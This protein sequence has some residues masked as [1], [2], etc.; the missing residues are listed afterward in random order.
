MKNQRTQEQKRFGLRALAAVLLMLVALTC[1][2]AITAS[3]TTELAVTRDDLTYPNVNGTFAADLGTGTDVTALFAVSPD[4]K[5]SAAPN[6]DVALEIV[7]AT[8]ADTKLGA[9]TVTVNLALTGTDAG[10]YTVSTLVIPAMIYAPNDIPRIGVEDLTF[11][12]GTY[13]NGSYVKEYNGADKIDAS[14]DVTLDTSSLTLPA[15]VGLV[16]DTVKLNAATVLEAKTLT[17]TFKLVDLDTT[18]AKDATESYTAPDAIVIPAKVTPKTVR[19]ESGTVATAIDLVYGQTSYDVD[20][21]SMLPALNAGDII[22]GDT[23]TVTSASNTFNGID[24]KQTLNPVINVVISNTN[25]AVEAIS[26]TVTVNPIV[27]TV[28]W[29]GVL[30]GYSWGD[31]GVYLESVLAYYNNN[32]VAGT[33]T[34]RL[35]VTVWNQDGS[36]QQTG[37]AGDVGK[38]RFQVA[39]PDEDVYAIANPYATFEITPVVFD[40]TMNDVTYIGNADNTSGSNTKLYYLP[41]G[42]ELPEAIRNQIRYYVGNE[43]FNGA[44]AY[45]TYVITAILPASDNYSFTKN[46][47]AIVGDEISATLCINRTYLATGSEA[48]KYEVVVVGKNGFA[49]D[50]TATVTKPVFDRTVLR[51]YPI[52][53]EFTLTIGGAE[54]SEGFIVYIPMNEEL[55]MR[56]VDTPSADDLYVYEPATNKIVKAN[57]RYTVSIE[58][59]YYVIEGYTGSQAITFV[60]APHYN[61]P[62]LLSAP[63]IALMILLVFL[64]LALMFY[65][66]IKLLRIKANL[67]ENEPIVID[68]VGEAYEGEEIVVE[69]GEGP[70]AIDVDALAAE[71]EA[72]VEP[73]SEVDEA[74]VD[75]LTEEAVDVTIGEL[76][77]EEAEEEAVEEAAE[78]VVEEAVEEATEEVAE[79]AVEEVVE[80]ATEEAA[81]EVVEEVVEET[82]EEAVEETAEEPEAVEAIAPV[83]EEESEEEDGDDEAEET[84]EED[85]GFGAFGAGLKYIDINADPEGYAEMLEQERQGLITIAYRYRKSYSSRLIQSQGNVQDYYTAIKNRLLSYKGIKDRISWNYEAFNRGRAHAAKINVKTKT[86]YLY[87]ALDPEALAGTKYS[88]VD[89]SAKKKYASV[90]VLLKIKGDR[91]FKHALELIDML[92]AEK[93]ALK[94]L[95]GREDVDYRIPYK[96]LEELVEEGVVKKLAAGVPVEGAVPAEAPVEEAAEE[97]AVDAPVEDVAEAPAEEAAAEEATEN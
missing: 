37:F 29:S 53:S 16:I 3:A 62:F 47:Q 18:D 28:D 32:G 23:V 6:A 89:V 43:A 33:P 39:S 2:L 41:V 55:Y 87:L 66:G 88:F 76:A 7:S 27:I 44:S 34:F 65:V 61:V 92:G 93:L 42:G 49:A 52:H 38:Y 67:K 54:G 26:A 11:A 24:K 97:I 21:L 50:I 46:G 71:L 94:K 63:G 56:H 40:I 60:L 45:G 73:Q 48:D 22:A 58:K 78:E 83:S 68:T 84:E 1:C 17:V 80:E 95:E 75:A 74:A 8:L 14:A 4:W 13:V 31:A 30:S 57:T 86:L 25:Y 90:P 96:T 5:Q 70:P 36:L 9:T 77:A 10:N 20:F 69:D 72:E 85:A 12:N 79:E 35:N 64:L 81:E 82:A 59:G 91:K 51:N 19:W 15:G